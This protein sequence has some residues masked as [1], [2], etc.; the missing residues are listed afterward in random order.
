MQQILYG[1]LLSLVAA[2][3]MVGSCVVRSKR[4]VFLC[5]S[6]ECLILAL[7]SVLFFNSFAGAVT[8]LISTVRNFIVAMDRFSKRSVWLFVA[9][10]VLI[11]LPL[12]NRGWIGLL[13]ILATVEYTFC[14]Y[15][16]K[17][18]LGTRCS[19][20]VNTGIWVIYSFLILDFSTGL[21]DLVVL[22]IDIAA[23][24]RLYNE[25]KTQKNTEGICP[26]GGFS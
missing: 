10:T 7:A 12:N 2:G 23:I 20:L 14:S 25:Q 3:F 21:T 5:Q 6:L 8:L 15:L 17:S 24:F 1:N 26:F 18:V 9:L 13:P 4:T 19:I 16:I 11:G 22:T